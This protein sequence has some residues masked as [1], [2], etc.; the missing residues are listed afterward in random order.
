MHPFTAT[1]PPHLA[2]LLGLAGLIPFVSGTGAT[3]LAGMT[4]SAR[5]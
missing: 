2:W 5:P 1:R 3:K 4:S